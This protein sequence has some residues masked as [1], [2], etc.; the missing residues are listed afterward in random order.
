MQ[1]EAHT[2]VCVT[3]AVSRQGS[4]RRCRRMRSPN[5]H[6]RAFTLAGQLCNATAASVRSSILSCRSIDIA[7]EA[8]RRSS[9]PRQ[10]NPSTYCVQVC[11]VF[12]RSPALGQELVSQQLAMW[13]RRRVQKLCG[14]AGCRVAR[15]V[16]L[17]GW[18]QGLL[19]HL[20]SLPASSL[21]VAVECWTSFESR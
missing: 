16:C 10:F 9:L 15:G 5:A 20:N 6:C 17:R 14:L 11:T 12:A 1:P 2:A 4:C 18:L 7:G 8:S 13:L 21:R 19:M 3:T